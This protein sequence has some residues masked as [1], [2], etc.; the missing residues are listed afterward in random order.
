MRPIVCWRFVTWRT[1]F[2]IAAGSAIRQ[3]GAFLTLGEKRPELEKSAVLIFKKNEISISRWERC[4]T[5][6]WSIQ[7]SIQWSLRRK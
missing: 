6:R 2:V 5:L 3:P 4:E 7:W 1:Q